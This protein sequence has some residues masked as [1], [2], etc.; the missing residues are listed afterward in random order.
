M[1]GGEWS[2]V[3]SSVKRVEEMM[4]FSYVGSSIGTGF[5]SE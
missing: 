3:E 5:Y 1:A 4:G 2:E